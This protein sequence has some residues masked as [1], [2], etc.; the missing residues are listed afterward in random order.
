M[1]GYNCGTCGSCGSGSYQSLDSMVSYS[2]GSNYSGNL[3]YMVSEAMPV[4]DHFIQYEDKKDL[5][6]NVYAGSSHQPVSRSYAASDFLAPERPRTVFVGSANEIR[7][8]VEEAF[9]GV[10]GMAFPDDI[11]IQLLGKKEFMKANVMVGGRWQDGI[12]GFALNRKKS[13]SSSEV[14]VRKGEMDRIMITLG[15]EIGHVLTG[16]LDNPTVEEAK[17][18]AFSIAWMRKIKESNIANLATAISLDR[19][20][21]NGVH[22]K[23]LN[24]VLKKIKEGKDPYQ[25]YLELVGGKYVNLL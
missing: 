6:S 7:E 8:F 11:I 24:F 19:P 22:D 20:A 2:S 12:M 18:F 10:T 5:Y 15:H 16:T 14:F 17:A 23:A 3:S 4:Q 25:L 9:S 21:Q 1:C 13:G